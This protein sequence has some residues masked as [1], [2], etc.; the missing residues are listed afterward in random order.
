MTP[1]RL[2]NDFDVWYQ[3][4]GNIVWEF[5]PEGPTFLVDRTYFESIRENL[6]MNPLSYGWYWS[7]VRNGL[8][9]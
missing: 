1:M 3:Y 8:E 2:S 5:K 4:Y 6:V 7:G 9:R